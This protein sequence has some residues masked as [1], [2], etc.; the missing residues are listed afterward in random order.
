MS[1]KEPG[2]RSRVAYPDVKGF[3]SRNLWY[4]KQWYIFYSG[5][6][7]QTEKLHQLGSELQRAE[8]Q[9]PVKMTERYG[10]GWSEKTLRHCFRNTYPIDVNSFTKQEHKGSCPPPRPQHYF[11]SQS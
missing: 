11:T 9:N 7:I 1:N 3:S 6:S 4:M 2:I 8:N 10:S 5:D